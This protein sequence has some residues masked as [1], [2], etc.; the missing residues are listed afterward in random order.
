MTGSIESQEFLAYAVSLTLHELHFKLL[1][2]AIGLI[3]ILFSELNISSRPNQ[4]YVD[5]FTAEK[6]N[7]F[8]MFINIKMMDDKCWD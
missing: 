5:D 3:I 8:M 1:I 4:T 7:F 2:F 6:D